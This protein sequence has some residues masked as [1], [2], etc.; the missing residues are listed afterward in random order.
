LLKECC[1]PVIVVVL[2]FSGA[3]TAASAAEDPSAHSVTVHVQ[4][5]VA[6]SRW[7]LQPALDHAARAFEA[8]GIRIDWRQHPLGRAVAP[9]PGALVVLLLSAE[10]T[11][12]K[13]AQGEIG[14]SVL[15]SSSLSAARAWIFVG[16][17]A[18]VTNG[19][20][21]A[22][23]DILG[24]VI[25]HELGHLLLATGVHDFGIMRD[26]VVLSGAVSARF[27][28]GQALRMRARLGGRGSV[29]RR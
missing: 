8:A 9:E 12:R 2:S 17:I 7:E 13:D 27:T 29:A 19:R 15:G 26:H 24:Q 14:P 5:H 22:L 6:I 18:D 4:S 21:L 23:P 16:R 3:G 25:A 28:T 10:M 1:T 11:N 20:G